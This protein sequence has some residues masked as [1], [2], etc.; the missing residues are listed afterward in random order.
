VHVHEAG[1][2]GAPAILF[3]HALGT[4][5]WMWGDVLDAFPDRHG[6]VPDL[7][8][9]GRSAGLPWRS[10]DDT[11]DGL[12]DLVA[13]RAAGGRAHVVG[14]SL[15][16]N[17]ALRL[18]VRH[19]DRVD[20]MV[21][22]GLNVLPLPAPGLMRLVGRVMRPFLKTEPVLRAQ[23]RALRIP[24]DRYAG[25][26]ESARAMAPDA[27]LRIGDELME[28]RLTPELSRA[29]SPTLAV[30]GSREHALIRRSVGAIARALPRAEG[31]LAPG[32]G[33]GWNG[34]AP[35]LFARTVRAWLDGAALPAELLPAEGAGM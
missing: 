12:A 9:H 27:F 6:L 3:L 19:P 23:A 25:Y 20:R 5:G 2:P 15:G 4:S 18:A 34:E 30:A 33:H 13:R 28:F 22:S 32:V 17:V 11:V 26:R 16:A 35:D 8:G 1:P 24:S 7:P 21:L 14:L 31:R 29:P 10:L